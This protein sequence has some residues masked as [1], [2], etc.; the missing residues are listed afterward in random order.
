MPRSWTLF[1]IYVDFI[2]NIFILFI[3]NSFILFISI[4]LTFVFI[5]FISICSIT[6]RLIRLWSIRT[7]FQQ[8]VF[9]V[10]KKQ[11]N[12]STSSS[13]LNINL[14]SKMF[15][16][17]FQVMTWVK[18]SSVYFLFRTFP[19]LVLITPCLVSTPFSF[20]LFS[21]PLY[22]NVYT[23]Y[24]QLPTHISFSVLPPSYFLQ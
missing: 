16:R 4:Y 15:I 2:S 20:S 21:R 9:D 19:C 10:A 23:S 6:V 12:T 11:I 5:L 22:Y 1:L 13:S 17:I 8:S 7:I 3:S 18:Q 14:L 24:S